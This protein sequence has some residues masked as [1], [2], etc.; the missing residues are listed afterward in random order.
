MRKIPISIYQIPFWIDAKR[1][2]TSSKYNT[3]LIYRIKGC[4]DEGALS[5]TLSSLVNDLYGA[6]KHFFRETEGSIEQMIVNQAAVPLETLALAKDC[7]DVSGAIDECIHTICSRAF[8]LTEPPLYRFCLL[9]IQENDILLVLNFSHIVTDAFTGRFLVNTI[10]ALYNHYAYQEPFPIAPT[11]SYEDYIKNE[12][13]YYPKAQ[14]ELDLT[15]WQKKIENKNLSITLP[16]CKPK[17]STAKA[18]GEYYFSISSE[19]FDALKAL[20]KQESTTIFL[21]LSAIYAVLL[22]R[23]TAQAD[24]CFT[25]YIDTR[26]PGYKDVPGCFVNAVLMMVS[27][28]ES[29]TFRQVITKLTQ[30]R[31]EAKVHQRYPLTD[32]MQ[33][34]KRSGS[35]SS[36]DHVNICLGEV[37]LCKEPLQIKNMDVTALNAK[38]QES[39]FDLFLGYQ[40][41]DKIEFRIEYQAALFDA[42]YI[43]QFATHFQRILDHCLLNIQNNINQFGLL[44]DI[45]K[46]KILF[47]WNKR[48]QNSQ[49]LQISQSPQTIHH[50]FEEQVLRDPHGIAVTFEDKT[51]TFEQL[52]TKANQLATKLKILYSESTHS[53][54][55]YKQ[56]IVAICMDRQCELV[57]GILAV[58][59]SGACYLPIDPMDVPFRIET[60]LSN[61][62]VDIVLTLQKCKKLSTV[63]KLCK[64]IIK[65]DADWHKIAM[66]SKDNLNIAGAASDLAYI[67]HTSGTTGTPKGVMVEHKSVLNVVLDLKTKLYITK[68]NTIVNLTSIAFDVFGF[69]LF[70]AW[71]SGA[72]FLLC[73]KKRLLDPKKITEFFTLNTHLVVNATP[74]V[75]GMI[76]PYLKPSTKSL[77]ILCGG[78]PLTASL[79]KNLFKLSKTIWNLYGPTEATIYSVVQKV[80]EADISH[81]NPS[82]G[83]GIANTTLYVL[84]EWLNLVPLGVPGEL[85]IGGMGLARG[86]L[87]DQTL[88]DLKFIP[89]LFSEQ[90]FGHLYKTGDWVSWTLEG[91]LDY[92]GRKDSQLKIRGTRVELGEIEAILSNHPQIASCVVT[93]EEMALAFVSGF[94]SA[95]K[96]P[97]DPNIIVYYVPKKA[98]IIQSLLNDMP[99]LTTELLV[100]YLK[101]HLSASLYPKAIVKL[102]RIPLTLTGKIDRTQLPNPTDTDVLQD[103]EITRPFDIIELTLKEIWIDIL[104]LNINKTNFGVFDDFFLMG[105]HSIT[106]V[107]LVTKIYECFKVQYPVAWVEQ[108]KTIRSQASQILKNKGKVSV[109]NPIISFNKIKLSNSRQ[110]LFM[111]HPALSG[112]EIYD[113]FARYLHPDIP[114]YGIDSYN[115]NSGKRWLET[116]ED[117]A[118]KYITYLKLVNPKGPYFLGGWS[119]GGTI[120]YEMAR[121]L[122]KMGDVVPQLYLLDTLVFQPGEMEAFFEATNIEELLDAIPKSWSYYL[123]ELP[124]AYLDRIFQCFKNDIWMLKNYQ[125]KPYSGSVVLIKSS[126]RFAL[127]KLFA[128]YL[129]GGW[130]P[131][132]KQLSIK[133]IEADHFTIMERERIKKVADII[134]TEMFKLNIPVIP[135]SLLT[136]TSAV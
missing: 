94:E 123:T 134:K 104:N 89:D 50:Y 73:S 111:V 79:T 57:I 97:L 28:K 130:K 132:I 7:M 48:S 65:L 99:P 13:K 4:L 29:E 31:K 90:P 118:D 34:M 136:D 81:H 20:A 110:P 58:L 95:S 87:N 5:K 106:A 108:Y 24:I 10:G 45:E 71:F 55:V 105:G 120:A 43:E 36:N 47:E 1:N 44:T 103:A 84:D 27:L 25:Y 83:A 92:I 23:Y 86:Y 38:K 75:W 15:F 41:S 40:V 98:S 59:K 116:I 54:D 119:F 126:S 114:L 12:E 133:P 6:G 78:E 66:Y 37:F 3:P 91:K 33:V 32:I 113:E 131:F 18:V 82:I 16:F 8:N 14:R 80:E 39:F 102:A 42:V 62:K 56:P 88:T 46:Q 93:V 64:H 115:L 122:E 49:T 127:N 19:K 61:A 124:T 53:V 67:I 128:R 77:T 30:Q 63:F 74:T 100:E 70:M 51:L 52:N 2:P 72:N 109:Y 96:K 125:V 101:K 21:V 129:H 22:Y 60:M 135:M 26:P 69:D 121:K 117:L 112:A 11:H 76:S 9:K 68:Y 85:Y 35:I 107:Y 17:C